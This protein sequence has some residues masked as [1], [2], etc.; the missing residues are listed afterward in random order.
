MKV[1]YGAFLSAFLLA[2]PLSAFEVKNPQSEESR[3][4][5]ELEAESAQVQQDF[6]TYVRNLA[7]AAR[8]NVDSPPEKPDRVKELQAKALNPIVLFRW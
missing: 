5:I 4:K 7:T 3:L 6:D 8:R 1:A 2:A